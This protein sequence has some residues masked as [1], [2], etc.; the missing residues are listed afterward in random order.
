[1][2]TYKGTQNL[3]TIKTHTFVSRNHFPFSELSF[4]ILDIITNK[5]Q[6]KFAKARNSF[7]ID[8]S[9]L[10]FIKIVR[11]STT[12]NCLGYFNKWPNWATQYPEIQ[13]LLAKKIYKVIYLL[14]L[15]QTG[16]S[17]STIRLTYQAINYYH[18]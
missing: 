2:K 13:I 4:L 14:Y 10:Y 9:V 1:M 15:S 6:K 7:H 5:L 16:R 11:N 17:Y 18:F 12:K 8:A 3:K